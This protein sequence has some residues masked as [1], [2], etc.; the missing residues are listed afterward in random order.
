VLWLKEGDSN[1]RFFHKVANSHRISNSMGRLEVD[2]VF[3][4]DEVEIREK[5]VQFYTSLYQEPEV[6]RPKVDGLAFDSI[7]EDDKS[8]LERPFEKEEIIKTLKEMKGDKAL[9]P[10]GFTIAFYLHCWRVVEADLLA[11]FAN[12]HYQGELEKSLNAS[13]IALIPKKANASNIRD[14]RPIS[15]VGSVYKLVSKV[16]AVRLKSVLDKVISKSQNAFVGGR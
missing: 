10:D 14:F 6:W 11:F 9:G 4:E 7:S 8:W 1:T 12:F 3:Y 13:F 2:R 5:V 16:L 15:L